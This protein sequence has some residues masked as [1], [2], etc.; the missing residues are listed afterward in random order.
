MGAM[1][2]VTTIDDACQYGV[3]EL[4][5]DGR[6]M[7]VEEKPQYPKSNLAQTGIYCYDVHVFDA[8][9]TLTPSKRGELEVSDLNMWY[10]SRGLLFAETLPGLWVDAGTSHDELLRANLRIAEA[11]RANA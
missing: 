8:I 2:F 9:R 5:P 10:A 1:M 7:G 6:L 11:R 3:V 4:G